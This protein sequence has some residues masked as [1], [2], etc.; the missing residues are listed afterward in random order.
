MM[1]LGLNFT[2][3]YAH[4]LQNFLLTP[5]DSKKHGIAEGVFNYHL[6]AC[7]IFAECAFGEIDARF[8]TF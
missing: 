4:A 8:G 6:S 5:Y 1:A 2:G 7:R 3:D